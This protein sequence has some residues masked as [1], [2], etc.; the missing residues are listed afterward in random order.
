MRVLISAS[1]FPVHENDGLPRFVYDLAQA[2]ANHADVTALTPDAP[3]ALRHERMGD[4]DVERFTYFLPRDRQCL[5]YG[6]GI[7]DNLRGSFAAKLQPPPFIACQA[8]A[9]RSLARRRDVAVVNSHWIIPQ[10]LSTALARGRRRRF[11]HV[12]TVHAGDVYLLQSLPFG[13]ALA[14][15]VAARSDVVSA[16]GSHVRDSLDELLGRP[17]NAAL[18]PMGAN[19]GAFREGPPEPSAADRFPSGYLLFFG[20]FSEKKGTVYLLRA[21]PRV[22]ERHGGLGLVVIGYGALEDSLR[23]EARALGIEHA[24]DFVGRKNHEEIGRYLRG[25][26]LAV[27]PSIVDSKGETEGMPTVVVEALA[28]GT[29]VVAS[30]VDG[31][32]DVI[33]HRE[34]GWLC[35]EKDPGDLA[36]KILVALDDPPDSRVLTRGAQTADALDWSAVAAHYAEIFERVAADRARGA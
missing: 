13:R 4:V 21:L 34:N 6:N 2:L 32:P 5:A 7:R 19:V 15:F 22:L 27:V 28:S 35:A 11:G 8:A 31:I 3:G 12:L 20:R 14:R 18:Q 25:C 10:G 1:T 9:T 26:R 23:A 29:R 16:V 17:S 36:E 30:R 24:V 33:R